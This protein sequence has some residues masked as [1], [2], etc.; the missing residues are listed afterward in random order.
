[1]GRLILFSVKSTKVIYDKDSGKIRAYANEQ[2]NI[3]ALM[4]N[5][6]NVACV[7]IEPYAVPRRN[8]PSYIDLKTLTL[9]L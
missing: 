7:Q 8:P 4:S 9:I 6:T 1:M 2:Q 5:F 3:E